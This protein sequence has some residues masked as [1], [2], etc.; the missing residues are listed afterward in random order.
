MT[1]LQVVWSI[2]WSCEARSTL[3]GKAMSPFIDGLNGLHVEVVCRLVEQD[4]VRSGEHHAREHT[5]HLFAAGEDVDGLEHI[6]AGEQHPAEEAAEVDIVLLGRVLADPVDE[7]FGMAV[8]ILAV[9]LRE[10]AGGDGLAPL[11]E[12]SSGSSSPMRILNMVVC[13]SSFS[14]TKAILSFCRR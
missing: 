9:V 6:V 5:A 3:P 2:S 14:P 12:P 8:E 10:I 4:D 11:T 13:A 1:R 7:G